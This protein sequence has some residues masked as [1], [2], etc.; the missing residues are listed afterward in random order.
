MGTYFSSI[1]HVQGLIAW[2][3]HVEGT[4]SFAMVSCTVLD[5]ADDPA[6]ILLD[7]TPA[8]LLHSVTLVNGV[9]D[10]LVDTTPASMIERRVIVGVISVG[11]PNA[12]VLLTEP[13][14]A[15]DSVLQTNAIANPTWAVESRVPSAYMTCVGSIMLRWWCHCVSA[16]GVTLLYCTIHMPSCSVRHLFTVS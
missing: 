12:D 2:Q 11:H 1:R 16:H 8:L 10:G 5:L 14:P 7:V 3:I 13:Y 15:V 9:T 4:S 6:A